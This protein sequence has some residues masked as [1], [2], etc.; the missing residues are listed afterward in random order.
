MGKQR[1]LHTRLTCALQDS[2]PTKTAATSRPE[3]GAP[4]ILPYPSTYTTMRTL[5]QKRQ[6]DLAP[7]PKLGVL[8]IDYDYEPA[9]GDASHPDTYDVDTLHCRVTGLT[10]E[11]CQSSE[12]TDEVRENF[13]DSVRWLEDQGVAGITSNCGFMAYFQD[14][15]RTVTR[16]PVFL[17]TLIQL[18][19][20]TATLEENAQG[21]IFTSNGSNFHRQAMIELLA[22]ECGSTL[23]SRRFVVVGCED[24]PGFEA[25]ANGEKVDTSLVGPGVVAKAKEV[26]RAHGRVKS[27][28]FECTE[29]PPYSNAVR[30]AVR[31]PVFDCVTCANTFMASCLENP[32]FGQRGW[33]ALGPARQRVDD[34]VSLAKPATRVSK[35]PRMIST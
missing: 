35:R 12:L 3:Q 26:L 19:F 7:R 33:Q 9:P 13:L 16:L 28:L 5:S 18:P 34:V 17:S 27:F 8:A 10:F 21:A 25:V 31:L 15:A 24:I 30:A 20:I 6:A 14:L 32:K 29:L 23:A 2:R 1:V 22:H 11:M 4:F